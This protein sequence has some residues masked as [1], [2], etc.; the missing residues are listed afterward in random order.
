MNEELEVLRRGVTYSGEVMTV[1]KAST[2][3]WGPNTLVQVQ[4]GATSS[5]QS[6]PAMS[7]GSTPA[8]G[9][10]AEAYLQG[11]KRACGRPGATSLEELVGA[12]VLVLRQSRL[13]IIE[14]LASLTEDYVF[15]PEELLAAH[16]HEWAGE[17]F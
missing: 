17:S 10:F 13:G 14:A 1:R 7:L 6:L 12:E 16:E 4:L 11:L 15:H 3:A 8:H 5:V 2:E 9:A